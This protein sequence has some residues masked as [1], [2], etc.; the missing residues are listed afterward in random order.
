MACMM[1]QTSAVWQDSVSKPHVE[2]VG[3]QKLPATHSD[4]SFVLNFRIR[5]GGFLSSSWGT[6]R[7][8]SPGSNWSCLDTLALGKPPSWSLSNAAWYEAFSEDVGLGSPPPTQAD[9][10]H[11]LCLPNLQVWFWAIMFV[12]E[13]SLLL[14]SKLLRRS[15]WLHCRRQDSLIM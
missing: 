7:I 2:F 3:G 5:T 4:F 13:N 9:S 1:N 10:P 6:H 11:H 14:F 8:H 12:W 15:C